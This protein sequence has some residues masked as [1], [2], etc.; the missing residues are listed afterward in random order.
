MPKKFSGENTKAVAARARKNAAKEEEQLRKQK[1]KED[2]YWRDDDKLINKKL[3]RKEEQEKKKQAQ[4]QRKAELKSLVEQEEN[5]LKSSS[6]QAPS[7][8]TRAQIQEEH[9][10]RNAAATKKKEPVTHIEKPLE[11]NINRVKVDG[12]EARSVTEAISVL[13]VKDQPD[14]KHPEKRMKAAYTAYEAAN[15]PRLKD[16]NPTLKLSQLKQLLWKEWTRSPEN[17]LNQQSKQ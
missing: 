11:E 3:Q 13:S 2:E 8:I 6:K 5:A 4:L 17:P 1:E 16:E 14:D 12:F 10:R 15:L 9:E 7:K